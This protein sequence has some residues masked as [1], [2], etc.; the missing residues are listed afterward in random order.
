MSL[1]AVMPSGCVSPA[2]HPRGGGL[3]VSVALAFLLEVRTSQR[4]YD[5]GS[6]GLSIHTSATASAPRPWILLIQRPT[7][8]T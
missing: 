7:S 6:G 1:P 8:A 2:H 5:G 3:D 4:G